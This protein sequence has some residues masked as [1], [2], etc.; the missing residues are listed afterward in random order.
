M[1]NVSAK[2]ILNEDFDFQSLNFI[3]D[4]SDRLFL[5]QLE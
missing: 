3:D 2:E 4:G 5:L 1:D